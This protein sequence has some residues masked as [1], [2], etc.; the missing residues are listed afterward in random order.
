MSILKKAIAV[1]NAVDEEQ[2]FLPDNAAYVHALQSKGLLAPDLPEPIS[3][4]ESRTAAWFDGDVYAH[5][6]SGKI[7]VIVE[8]SRYPVESARE[9]ALSIL[10]AC[11][12]A[13][14]EVV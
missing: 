13:E 7:R 3:V 11:D 5:E 12:Y 8:D 6:G 9:L 1:L 4:R 2:D 10:A 14:T